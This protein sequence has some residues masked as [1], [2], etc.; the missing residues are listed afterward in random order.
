M[1]SHLHA[2]VTGITRL[3]FG[4]HHILEAGADQLIVLGA[5][6]LPDQASRATPAT[7]N[8]IER[9]AWK[10]CDVYACMIYLASF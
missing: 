7:S 3:R 6:R 10:N 2:A 4:P 1:A 5:L 9:I 8:M